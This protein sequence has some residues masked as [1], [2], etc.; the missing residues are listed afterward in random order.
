MTTPAYIGTSDLVWQPDQRVSSFPSGLLLVQRT[1][2]SRKTVPKRSDLVVGN[3][4]TVEDSGAIDGVFI[5][6]EVQ[7]TRNPAFIEYAVSGYGRSSDQFKEVIQERSLGA[8]SGTVN[9]AAVRVQARTRT[10]IQRGVIFA[11][12]TAPLNA[13]AFD[14]IV[15]VSYNGTVYEVT[16]VWSTT[17]INRTN[18]GTFDEVSITWETAT[19]ESISVTS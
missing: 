13:P 3:E 18:F 11:D 2:T 12:E 4:M 15:T 5:F 8:M 1:A 9:G 14:P 7:E 16:T 10:V 19:P 17:Q 6:P